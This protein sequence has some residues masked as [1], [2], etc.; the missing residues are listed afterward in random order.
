M[1]FNSYLLLLLIFLIA[2]LSY[3]QEPQWL[4]NMKKIV[5]LK[6]TQDDVTKLLGSPSDSVDPYSPRY[7][8]KERKF[9][10]TYSEGFCEQNPKSIFN[11][12][13]Y[14][15][16]EITFFPKK[17][18]KPSNYGINL[19]G[20]NVIPSE[21]VPKAASYDNS[22]LGINYF[23]TSKGTIEHVIF[24]APDKYRNLRCPDVSK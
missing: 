12:A 19:K 14:T 20:F 5:P 15:V 3:S 17:P 24:F 7:I 1:K 11:V 2:N 22:E 6:S 21:D 18:F 8:N 10:I 23:L 13:E 4:Q 16:I 9:L